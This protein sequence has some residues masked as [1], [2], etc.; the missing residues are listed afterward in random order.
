MKVNLLHVARLGI[1]QSPNVQILIIT[2]HQGCGVKHQRQAI[3]E[4][5]LRL[6]S[7][8]DGERPKL[9]EQAVPAVKVVYDL[10][11]LRQLLCAEGP[12]GSVQ[13]FTELVEPVLLDLRRIF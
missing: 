6:V 3:T 9:R 10:H 1:W 8:Q 5:D 11:S 2:V 4:G 12:T 7:T 13:I